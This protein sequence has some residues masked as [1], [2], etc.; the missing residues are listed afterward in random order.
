[1]GRVIRRASAVLEEHKRPIQRRAV[2]AAWPL[3]AAVGFVGLLV[4]SHFNPQS[5][6]ALRG[7]ALIWLLTIGAVR[8]LV[9]FTRDG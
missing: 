5:A 8:L 1:M 7:L 9:A 2:R 6:S 3:I 4:A